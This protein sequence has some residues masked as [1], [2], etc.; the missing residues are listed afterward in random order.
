MLFFRGWRW[1]LIFRS[2]NKCWSCSAS[3]FNFISSLHFLNLSVYP[4]QDSSQPNVYF[5]HVPLYRMRKR[6][7]CRRHWSFKKLYPKFDGLVK[8]PI[9]SYRTPNQ[10]EGR[11]WSGIQ[12]LLKLLDSGSLIGVRDKLRRNDKKLNFRL[13]TNSSN[14]I[15]VLLAPFCGHIIFPF[16]H[17]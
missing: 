6:H 11:L 2:L 8:S 13:F 15:F 14:L 3:S 5:S 10:V 7:L 16:L 4:Y 9:S 17:L 12:N 1:H